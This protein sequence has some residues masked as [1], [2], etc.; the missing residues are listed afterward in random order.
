MLEFWCLWWCDK[1]LGWHSTS[2]WLTNNISSYTKLFEGLMMTFGWYKYVVERSDWLSQDMDKTWKLEPLPFQRWQ[3]RY[4]SI[5][6]RYYISRR[7]I[8]VFEKFRKVIRYQS[9]II[10]KKLIDAEGYMTGEL[11][12]LKLG[13]NCSSAKSGITHLNCQSPGVDNRRNERSDLW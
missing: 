6:F 11:I 4:S 13:N 10:L 7:F 2:C 12:M 9:C 1:V 5:W 8:S 3:L